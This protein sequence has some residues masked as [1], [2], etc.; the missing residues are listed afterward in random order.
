M[1][2]DTSEFAGVVYGLHNG[3]YN[4]RYIGQ[5]VQTMRDRMDKH[6]SNA[7]LGDRL[8]VYV[9]MRE[10]GIDNIQVCVIETFTEDDMK[11][12]NDREKFHISQARSYER[13]PWENMNSDK[14]GKGTVGYTR[15]VSAET[16]AKLSAAFS[17]EK[18]PMYGKTGSTTWAGRTHTEESKAK[19]RGNRPPLTEEHKA[20][21]SAA[22]K[23]QKFSEET[24]AKM[25]ASHKARSQGQR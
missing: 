2:E 24:K 9:W 19:M 20:K 3:D 18:N 5:T 7:R 16:R 15:V 8:P 25:S 1:I 23:G 10:Y 21:I 12:L 22:R 11:W 14:G 13:F 17:G 4:Y 6:R